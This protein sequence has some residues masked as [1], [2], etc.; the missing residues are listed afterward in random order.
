MTKADLVY[1]ACIAACIWCTFKIHSFLHIAHSYWCIC[2]KNIVWH[3]FEVGMYKEDSCPSCS[4]QVL[5]ILCQACLQSKFHMDFSILKCLGVMRPHPSI[6]LW[7]GVHL[8]HSC[9]SQWRNM[10]FAVGISFFVWF[11]LASQFKWGIKGPCRR[12]KGCLGR[13]RSNE[14][15]KLTC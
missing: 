14:L 12:G 5:E 15:C 1:A 8:P 3:S 10:V 4:M 7:N 13:I 2:C 6:P 11:L 9:D